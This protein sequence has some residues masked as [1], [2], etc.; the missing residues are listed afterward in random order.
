MENSC[1][2]CG[3]PIT[4]DM[5]ICKTCESLHSAERAAIRDFAN[6]L[7]KARF[8]VDSSFCEGRRHIEEAVSVGTI[9]Q[10]RDGMIKELTYDK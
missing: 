6:R 4:D 7:L 8:R 10:V 2:C 5:K 9:E 1:V 3:E